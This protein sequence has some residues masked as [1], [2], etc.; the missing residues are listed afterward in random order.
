MYGEVVDGIDGH[1]F[2][3]R[4]RGA[5]AGARRRARTSTSTADDLAELST[6]FKRDLRGRRPAARSR[7][8]RASSCAAPIAPSS[9][10]GTRRARRSTGARTRSRTTS[11]P[12]STSCR[13]CSA[14]RATT[15]APGVCF[16]RDPST[17]ERGPLRRVPRQRAGRGRRRRHPHARAARARCS[18]PLPEAFDAARARRCAGSRSTTATCRT[19]S[20]R[21]RTG[22]LYLLQTRTAK[23]T[24]AAALQAAVEHGRR[25]ADHARGGGRAHRPGAAR[26]AAAPDDR[27]DGRGRGRGDG[28]ERLARAP[29]PAR[30][31]FDADTAGRA[32]RGGRARHPRPLGDD[33]RRHPRPDRGA[34]ASS[35]RTAA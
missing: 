27:P 35:P 22:R 28:A 9:T 1:R 31:C 7:R 25:G 20:S 13:W 19:S 15:R 11:A 23:R 34:G 12:P 21:S 32:R 26:P 5:E 17:G 24:A 29:R 3:Q 30:S 8:T 14:T 4:A 6:T 16:T 10:R 18:E 33:A 2:E